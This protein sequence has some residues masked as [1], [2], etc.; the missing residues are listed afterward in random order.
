MA[1]EKSKEVAV[2][3]Q[4]GEMAA[5]DY[6]EELGT[7][8]ENQTQADYKLS[9]LTVLQSLSPQCKPPKDGGI[10]GAQPGQLFITGEDAIYDPDKEDLVVIP[11]YTDHVFVEWEKRKN[12]GGFVAIHQITDPVVTEA[13]AKCK[14]AELETEAGN[15]LVETFYIYALIE[16][17]LDPVIIGFSSTK[18]K[19]YQDLM[20]KLRKHQIK[21][22]G[23]RRVNPPLFANRCLVKTKLQK[24]NKGEYYNFLIVPA[25]PKVVDKNTGEV[26]VSALAASLIPF[27]DPRIEAAVELKEMIRSGKAEI[28]YDAQNA[29]NGGA[30]EDEKA[31]F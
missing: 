8:F 14:F 9:W 24:N 16:H 22:D 18:I 27:D 21:V 2:K 15:D 19:I 23:G 6:G 26:T 13:K 12:G 28:N 4:A 1:N 29:G 17:S 7:G 5:Y 25:E 30:Q 3:A 31:H 10:E 11:C 20:T